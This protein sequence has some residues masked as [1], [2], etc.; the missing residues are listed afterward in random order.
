MVT[1]EVLLYGASVNFEKGTV[2]GLSAR[3]G[4]GK[5]T[6][7]RTISGLRSESIGTISIQEEN[8]ALSLSESKRRLFYYETVDWFDL[9]LSGWDY[10][11]FI[12]STWKK[13]SHISI[14]EII[15]FWDMSS[16]IKLPIKKYSLGMK[17]KVLLSMYGVS[18]ASYWLLDEPTI[19]L[20][21]NSLE[22]FELFI[23][24]AKTNGI[25]VLFSSHQ[26][27]S[28]YATC[29]YIYEI[30]GQALNL[31]NKK[32][33]GLRSELLYLSIKKDIQKSW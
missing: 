29:D 4:S 28:I 23:L 32:R 13:P 11:Q 18:G 2:Y 25:C 10:L 33:G 16:Y 15:T 30:N 14:D 1:R 19:G 7:L 8:Q 17:Q 5:T 6:L 21:T 20:D 24:E 9:N 27:D 26:N 12:Q 3:N 22:K 31:I